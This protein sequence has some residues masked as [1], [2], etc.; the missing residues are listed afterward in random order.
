MR[1]L[2][3]W[4]AIV[5]AV[6]PGA[7][8]SQVYFA[9]A[10]LQACV[11]SALGITTD[12]TEEDMQRLDGLDAGNQGITDLTGLEHA[13][14]ATY[15]DL[16][17]NDEIR[18]LT[19]LSG[20]ESLAYLDVD[21]CQVRD[22]EPLRGLVNLIELHLEYNLGLSNLDP[23]EGLV[24]LEVLHLQYC[25]EI[26]D[27]QPL[28]GLTRL[29]T[30]SLTRNR[31]SDLEP[32]SGL[33]SLEGLYLQKNGVPDVSALSGLTLLNTLDLRYNQIRN[34]GPLR[35]LTHLTQLN[36]EGNPL[37]ANACAHLSWMCSRNPLLTLDYDPCVVRHHA[38]EISATPGGRVIDPGEGTFVY[39]YGTPVRLQAEASPS[40]VFVGW[41]G[42]ISD[43]RN[44]VTVTMD[45]PHQIRAHFL[46]QLPVLYVDDDAPGD[47]RPGDAAG[48][49]PAENG[50]PEHPFDRI[51]EAVEVAAEG[52]EILVLSGVYR[53]RID[54]LGKAL[55]LTG[56][57]P[58]GRG[59]YPVIA[60]DG[61]GPVIRLD[62]GE[63]PNCTV[64]G[65]VIT[66]GRAEQGSG[67]YCLD[68]SPRIR[69]CLI[70]GNRS[71][72]PDGAAVYC[73]DSNA[74]F[75]HCTI[76]E[77]EGG[78]MV[79]ENSPVH[80]KDSIVWANGPRSIVTLGSSPTVQFSN[81][82]GG[83]TGVGS[84]D[85]DP[86]FAQGPA[87]DEPDTAKESEWMRDYHLQSQ[88][89]R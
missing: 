7:V 85:L 38:L 37:D 64:M 5:L 77:N 31:I 24:C 13:T 82:Q 36:I 63:D 18:D 35:D 50:S 80:L 16:G 56:M 17:R 43:T 28:S 8:A 79:L 84:I 33:A 40:F 44:P 75:E 59:P 27:L 9:D 42:T 30:L 26:S 68:G 47:P 49:D 72:H 6:A 62:R 23:L 48:S 41:S 89:G 53:E 22:L 46:S 60:G 51:Q 1:Q 55:R 3:V 74:V 83:W 10:Q 88:A 81:V 12:P 86:L 15:L 45:C 87:A 78:G 20:L 14:N 67:L 76:A 54:L 4:S 29:R 32:L 69:H 25:L 57:D 58:N 73:G 61:T 19:P 11:K 39:E 52:S 70:V 65:F 66:Q 34:V 2:L 71:T 21:Y